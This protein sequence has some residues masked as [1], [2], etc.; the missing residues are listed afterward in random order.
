MKINKEIIKP[1]FIII[2]HILSTRM[3][4]FGDKY[5][6]MMAYGYEILNNPLSLICITMYTII[7]LLQ[8]NKIKKE[9]FSLF[10]LTVLFMYEI[11]ECF[12]WYIYT[13]TGKFDFRFAVDSIRI[14]Y[15]IGV[16]TLLLPIILR[17]KKIK[18]NYNKTKS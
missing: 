16:I 5:H 2:P 3:I 8:I 7:N 15:V 14:G 12:V 11:I 1:F 9:I 13:I 4:W 10:S 17:Y 18:E 6:V